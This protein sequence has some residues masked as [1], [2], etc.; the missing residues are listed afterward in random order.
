MA[1]GGEEDGEGNCG[2]ELPVDDAGDV[3]VLVEEEVVDV[4]VGVLEGETV[5]VVVREFFWKI[6]GPF[7]YHVWKSVAG[8]D[9]IGSVVRAVDLV[10]SR[11]EVIPVIDGFDAIGIGRVFVLGGKGCE[12]AV[13]LQR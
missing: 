5:L 1:G 3:E 13:G 12:K 7:F 9:E 11:D 8:N 6:G 4:E 2:A 10:L